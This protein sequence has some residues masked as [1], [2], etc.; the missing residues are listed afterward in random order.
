M[1]K[2]IAVLAFAFLLSP[3]SGEAAPQLSPHVQCVIGKN[4][5]LVNLFDHA[6]G[7]EFRD[8]RCG[9]FGY[10]G[11][12]GIDIA[13]GAN[14][15]IAENIPVIAAAD[16]V[17]VGTRNTESDAVKSREDVAALST[18]ECGN[19]A[20]LDHGDGWNTQYCHMKQGS[21]QVKTGQQVKRGD[22]LGY[23]GLSG[24][25]EFAHAHMG[26][27]YN[28]KPIDPFA[29]AMGVEA[30]CAPSPGVQMWSEE[31]GYPK[32]AQIFNVGIAG[33]KPDWEAV[34]RSE[35]AARSIPRN[36]PA[37]VVWVEAFT[38]PAGTKIQYDVQDES[39]ATLIATEA[40][41]QKNRARVF[42][43]VGKKAPQGGFKPGQY[44]AK[45]QTVSPSG[46]VASVAEFSFRVD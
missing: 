40:V 37:L 43:F 33:G 19:G 16:G 23:V 5:W 39:G 20:R 9:W 45:V 22:V 29:P 28:N 4:C 42:N 38:S 10:D 14:S 1:K 13:I 8:F 44:R 27:F 46:D 3:H 36:A 7:P 6:A 24:K 18:K 17:V 12:D 30:Q 34:K 41:E 15:R 2:I 35:Y 25:T 11:H 26:V 31:M 32:G 21:V